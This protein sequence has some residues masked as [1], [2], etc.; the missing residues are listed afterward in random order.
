MLL[1]VQ[2]NCRVSSAL[3]SSILCAMDPLFWEGKWKVWKDEAMS[4][5]F[6]MGRRPCLELALPRQLSRSADVDCLLNYRIYL[7]LVLIPAL[8]HR[9]WPLSVVAARNA[10]TQ[11]VASECP[12]SWLAI[13]KRTPAIEK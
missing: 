10:Q 11:D 7:V 3:A 12:L 2:A 8:Q 6:C 13:C 9:H 1:V 4:V 5:R